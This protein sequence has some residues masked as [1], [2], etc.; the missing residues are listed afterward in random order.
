MYSHL[1]FSHYLA[2]RI[3]YTSTLH[4]ILWGLAMCALVSISTH[5]NNHKSN[6]I[7]R[8]YRQ[9]MLLCVV[10][11]E[12]LNAFDK[13][14]IWLSF[15]QLVFNL[16][17]S[18]DFTS[19]CYLMWSWAN[20]KKLCIVNEFKGWEM[21]LK[22]VTLAEANNHNLFIIWWIQQ[23]SHGTRFQRGSKVDSLRYNKDQ[24]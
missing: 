13:F 9:Q 20:N 17:I 1:F 19:E 10:N 14:I 4:W 23:Q 18:L 24:L 8:S 2:P 3:I 7:D 21:F 12:C 22:N 11:S 6:W 16:C 15:E 5:F